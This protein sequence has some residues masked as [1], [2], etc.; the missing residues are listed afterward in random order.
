MKRE[1]QTGAVIATSAGLVLAAATLGAPAATGAEPTSPGTDAPIAAVQA[2]PVTTLTSTEV[3]RLFKLL[4]DPEAESIAV[5][6]NTGPSKWTGPKLVHPE[7]GKFDPEVLQWAN[8]TKAVMKEQGIPVKYLPGVLAQM[9][10]ESSG[11]PDAVNKWDSNAVA[12]TPSK[13]L[14]QVIAPTYKAF[15]KKGYKSLDYQAV[16]YTN[17]YASLNYVQGSYGMA[18]FKSWNQGANQGY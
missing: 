12:G 8:L 9:Q 17:I 7:G 3:P 16:P 18:K 1:V 6:E 5:D 4:P 15:A 14:L 11:D 13:G 2:A 10:Q